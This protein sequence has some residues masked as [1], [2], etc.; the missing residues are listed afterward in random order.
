MCSYVGELAFEDEDETA[1]GGV[2]LEDYFRFLVVLLLL[3]DHDLLLLEVGEVLQR[4]VAFECP[5]YH[6]VVEDDLDFITEH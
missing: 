1:N 2:F 5:L 3:V 6:V 4:R